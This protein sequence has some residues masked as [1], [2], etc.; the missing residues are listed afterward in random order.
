MKLQKVV[1]WGTDLLL[2]QTLHG[3]FMF[4][5]LFQGHV[6]LNDIKAYSSIVDMSQK[7]ISCLASFKQSCKVQRSITRKLLQI[8]NSVRFILVPYDKSMINQWQVNLLLIYHI[9]F[10]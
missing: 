3:R 1:H 4:V 9:Y 6:C 7:C 2:F 8:C 10:L 5:C